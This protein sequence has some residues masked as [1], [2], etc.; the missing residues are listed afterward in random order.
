MKRA[1]FGAIAEHIAA[2]LLRLKGYRIMARQLRPLRG[3]GAGEIDIIARRGHTLAF[4]EVKARADYA[5]ALEALSPHQQGRL[6]R[7]ALAYIAQHPGFSTFNLRFDLIA[8]APWQ[9]PR[10]IQN[11]W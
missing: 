5:Q 1:N 8:I 11:A 2:G 9:R 3:S 6:Q 10:H 7:A 4:V